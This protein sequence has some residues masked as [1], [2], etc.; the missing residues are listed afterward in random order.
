MFNGSSVR[1]K[2]RVQ[3]SNF[4]NYCMGADTA[5]SLSEEAEET[6]LQLKVPNISRLEDVAFSKIV[7]IKDHQW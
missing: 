7:Q 3:E 6:V 2:L 4:E 1:I 5:T